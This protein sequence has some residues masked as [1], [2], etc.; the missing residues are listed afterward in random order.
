MAPILDHHFRDFADKHIVFD[1]QYHGHSKPFGR[2]NW[3]RGSPGSFTETTVIRALS[4]RYQGVGIRALAH[5]VPQHL[6]N[7]R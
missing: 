4:G 5:K 7:A 2:D 1:D 3:Y 6:K